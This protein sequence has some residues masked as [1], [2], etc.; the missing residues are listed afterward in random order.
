MPDAA[1]PRRKHTI[2]CVSYLNAKP[3]I[4]GVDG[5]DARVGFDVPSRLHDGLRDGRFDLA[6]CPVVDAFAGPAES[7]TPADVEI[8]PVGGIGCTGPTWTVRLF[9]RVPVE[10]ISGVHLDTDSHTS[11]ALLRVLFAELH[12][13]T[14]SWIDHDF[15]HG[16]P[17]DAEA[18]LLIGD[19]V[20]TNPPDDAA[21]PHQ[22]DLGDAWHRM[23]NLPFVFAV[24]MKRHG[25][26][27]GNLPEFL[28]RQLDANLRRIDELVARYA[29]AHGW[30]SDLAAD[31]LRRVLRYRVDDD[32]LAGIQRFAALARRHAAAPGTLREPTIVPA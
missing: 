26:D 29:A 7:E 10:H 11:V 21:Y 22:L 16:T 18:M 20:V 32:A 2:G 14:P 25:V 1:G 31:Y 30:P 4:H 19:K 3:L 6:L 28:S 8:V 5:P 12:G 15:A 17:A 23:T 9:S 13:R 24:W 27:L